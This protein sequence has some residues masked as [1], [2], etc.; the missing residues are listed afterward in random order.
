MPAVDRP[1]LSVPHELGADQFELAVRRLA[2]DLTFGADASRFVGSGVEYVQSRP[3]V[4]G[5]PVR[6]MDWRV[7]A[8]TGRY[9]VKE[10]EAT[11]RVG[12]FLLVDTSASMGVASTE[13]SKHDVA[14]WVAATL[15]V[16]ALRRRSPVAVLSCGEREG[17]ATPTL[18]HGQV[19]RSVEAL[20]TPSLVEGTRLAERV[21]QVETIAR[22]TSS[23][24]VLSDL[25]DPGA[26]VAIKRLAQRHDCLVL[27]LRDPV[28]GRGLRAGFVR[29]REA[30]TGRRLTA[31]PSTRWDAEHEIDM[32]RA[33][34]E[35]AELSV[36]QPVIPV[37][38]RALQVH[39]GGLRKAR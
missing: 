1:L 4:Q 27:R 9:H 15:A 19:W 35:F 33:G 29:T 30:E 5:D 38:R 31:G 14:V 22:Y 17:R 6:R 23:V 28:E 24:I 25:H 13:L 36:E 18:S 10:Y 16:V 20:R 37:L 11:K 21:E 12:V 34:V 32:R 2:D 3:F 39:G 26:S 8:R 7:T